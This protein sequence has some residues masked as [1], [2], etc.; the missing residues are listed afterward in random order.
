MQSIS[1]GKFMTFKT[2]D[3]PQ[4]YKTTRV[5]RIQFLIL[6]V[7]WVLLLILVTIVSIIESHKIIEPILI[8][9]LPFILISVIWLVV[10]SDM[11]KAFVEIKDDKIT[12]VD[13]YFG[14][15][16]VKFF[17]ITDIVNAEITSG[18]S[19]KIRGYRFGGTGFS[20]LYYVVF[21]EKRNK[22]LFKLLHTEDIKN[23]F[24]NN[25][26]ICFREK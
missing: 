1:K 19:M 7:V 15:K 13:F 17:Y 18:N 12:V 8:I 6:A 11:K 26:K 24:E 10:I 25:L 5:M 2:H 4:K 20:D 22:Y 14:I 3:L 23:Y 16:R 9:I 21:Y